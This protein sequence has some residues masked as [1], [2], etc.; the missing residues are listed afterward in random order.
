MREGVSG[1]SDKAGE[2]VRIRCGSSV[3]LGPVLPEFPHLGV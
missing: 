2:W 1:A 3:C